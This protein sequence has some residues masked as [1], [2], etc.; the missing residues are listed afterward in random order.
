MIAVLNLGISNLTSVLNALEFLKIDFRVANTT[1]EFNKSSKFILPGVGTFATSFEVIEHIFNPFEF[2]KII[3]NLLENDGFLM[4]TFPNYEGFDINILLEKCSFKTIEITTPGK[5][6]VDIVRKEILNNNNLTNNFLRRICVDNY[7]TIGQNFQ[8]FLAEN[9]L[10]S[11][12][13]VIARKI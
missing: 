12:M 4:L 10:S 5:L 13:M 6:D 7:E 11:H 2:L 9:L 3:Y 8:T 1:E